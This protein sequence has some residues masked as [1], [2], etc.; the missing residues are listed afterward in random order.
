MF[1]EIPGKVAQYSWPVI[2]IHQAIRVR[3]QPT[4]VILRRWR[5]YVVCE[6]RDT[7]ELLRM[8]DAQ[9]AFTTRVLLIV[10]QFLL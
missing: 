2:A 7:S 9:G 6:L 3:R 5:E 1:L 10:Y 4:L 8:D